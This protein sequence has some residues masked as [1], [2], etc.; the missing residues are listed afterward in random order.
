MN[1]LEEVRSKISEYPGYENRDTRSL[2]DELVR[3]YAGRRL[4]EVGA[5]LNGALLQSTREEFDAVL[6]RCQFTNQTAF[7]T[8]VEAEGTKFESL[9]AADATLIDLADRS[10]DVSQESMEGFLKDLTAA[11]DGR[12][13]AMD[14][15]PSAA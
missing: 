2:A 3:G 10:G 15:S 9:V 6:F 5:R 12:D 11:L 13:A 8:F 1:P 4:A 14:A 7:K